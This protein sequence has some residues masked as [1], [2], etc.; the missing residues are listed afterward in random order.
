M[1]LA[2]FLTIMISLAEFTAKSFVQRACSVHP[3]T[4]A[5]VLSFFFGCNFLDGQHEE[6]MRKGEI[7]KTMTD[8]WYR[9]SDEY[10][11]LCHKHFAETVRAAGTGTLL[12]LPE[13]ND[14]VDG[15][16]S[17]MILCDQLARN[18][19][20]GTQEAFAYDS[21]SLRLALQLVNALKGAPEDRLIPGEL[22]P[23]FVF[24]IMLPLMHSEDIENHET[25]LK[26]IDD[27]QA[28]LRTKETGEEQLVAVFDDQRSFALNHKIVLDRFGRYPH[29]NKKLGRETTQEE[30]MWL[31]DIDNLPG[32]A[33]SQG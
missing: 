25:C 1:N 11:A 17:Q 24:F 2:P 9:Q 20:R 13:W 19:F 29:R 32:W 21:T 12:T 3:A 7:L 26:V 14:S 30:R 8:I 18:C 23:P 33:K 28:Q 22:Y 31:E 16:M 4:P 27:F 5:S 6:D 10:D 15:L